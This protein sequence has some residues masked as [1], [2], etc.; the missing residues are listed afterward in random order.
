MTELKP[1]PFCGSEDTQG[2]MGVEDFTSD[3]EFCVTCWDCYA[4]GPTSF[5]S[6][7]EAMEKWN[8]RKGI[9]I[10]DGRQGI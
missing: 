9:D 10:N 8:D 1:C 2:M 3:V 5:V 7:D 4:V 6:L